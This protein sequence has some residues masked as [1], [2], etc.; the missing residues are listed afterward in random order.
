MKFKNGEIVAT[1]KDDKVIIMDDE[2]TIKQAFN[3]YNEIPFAIDFDKN[4]IIV[5]YERGMVHLYNRRNNERKEVIINFETNLINIQINKHNYRVHS[6]TLNQDYA[7]SACDD[8]TIQVYSLAKKTTVHTFKHTNFVSCVSFG[9]INTGYANKIIS[10]SADKTVRIWNIV[11]GRMEKEFKH[12]GSCR[13]FDIDKDA[14]TLAVACYQNSVSV[15][16]IRDQKQIAKI[17]TDS[18]ACDVRFNRSDNEIGV[19]C[20]DG[21]IYKVTL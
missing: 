16:S 6:V 14:A 10:S 5:G 1:A 4:N 7:V 20:E 17:K 21:E 19:G 15:W 13:S 2:L 3:G 11:N 9:P 12:Y 18:S 8:H